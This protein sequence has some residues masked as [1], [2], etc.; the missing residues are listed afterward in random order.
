[1]Q[2]HLDADELNLLAEILLEQ[3]GKN[4]AQG[5]SVANVQ[6]NGD[7]HQGAGRYDGMLDKVLARDLRLDGD[8]LEQV[9]VLLAERS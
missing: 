9:A 4:S 6:G 8:E 2:L 5:I 1:M 7:I 3:V